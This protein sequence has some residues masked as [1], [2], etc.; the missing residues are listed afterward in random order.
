MRIRPG[1]SFCLSCGRS[2]LPSGEAAFISIWIATVTDD[3]RLREVARLIVEAHRLSDT[4]RLSS[5]HHMLGLAAIE[6]ASEAFE[7]RELPPNV[8]PLRG[9]RT[10]T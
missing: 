10:T 5:V 8:V 4:H 6:A 1:V 2:T 9:A 7:L 3:E